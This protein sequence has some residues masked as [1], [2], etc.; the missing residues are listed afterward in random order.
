MNAK[1]ICYNNR[2]M[3][4]MKIHKILFSVNNSVFLQMYNT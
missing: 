2:L 3:F 1:D 4:Y